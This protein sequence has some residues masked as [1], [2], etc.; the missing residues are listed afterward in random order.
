MNTTKLQ[1]L[2]IRNGQRTKLPWDQLTEAEQYAMQFVHHTHERANPTTL[3]RIPRMIAVQRQSTAREYDLGKHVL[4]IDQPYGTVALTEKPG[5]DGVSHK[6][7]L[8]E[9][10]SYWLYTTLMQVFAQ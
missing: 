10:E 1:F 8:D 9:Q 3:A 7:Q 2:V 6:I 4:T 5:S